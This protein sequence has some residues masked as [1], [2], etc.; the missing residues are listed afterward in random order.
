M[1]ETGWGKGGCDYK[2]ATGG[3]F[4][5]PEVSC[6]LLLVVAAQTYSWHNCI[7]VKMHAGETGYM[8]KNPDCINASTLT[9]TLHCSFTSRCPWVRLW[10]VCICASVWSV[11]VRLQ[12]SQNK[13]LSS[14]YHW[15]HLS[16]Y[17]SFKAL[18]ER[19]LL[20]AV[21]HVIAPV[22]ELCPR[23]FPNTSLPPNT[24]ER[25]DEEHYPM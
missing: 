1:W 2:P 23:P 3:I 21:W 5:T 19:A 13:K 6:I 24:S 20:F 14:T 8:S 17:L 22:E 4:V 10:P 15:P 7:D 25:S 16:E 9:V 11:Y 12:W 18:K